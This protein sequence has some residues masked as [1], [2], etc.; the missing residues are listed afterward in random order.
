MFASRAPAI[1]PERLL[2]FSFLFFSWQDQI[3][4][5]NTRKLSVCNTFELFASV[6]LK[7][8]DTYCH[9]SQ[10]YLFF[11]IINETSDLTQGR[12]VQ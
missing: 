11:E 4:N 1:Q 5:R 2:Y 10:S 12:G 9:K 7:M 8:R 6:H 3:D